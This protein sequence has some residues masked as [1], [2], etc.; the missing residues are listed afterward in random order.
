VPADLG[1]KHAEAVF[2]VVIRDAFD[3]AR[4]DF[5]GQWLRLRIHRGGHVIDFV[6]FSGSLRNLPPCLTASG[7]RLI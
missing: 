7:K 5:L 1:A 6:S 2:G 3:E 4:Q